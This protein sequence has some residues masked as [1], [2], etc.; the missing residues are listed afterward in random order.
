MSGS[1]GCRADQCGS[2]A[3]KGPVT[4]MGDDDESLATLDSGGC[5][6]SV[7]LVLLDGERFAG[8]GRLINLE[9]CVLGDNTAIG[10]D[11]STL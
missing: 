7:A 3:N 6:D 11:D 1:A 4:G 5:V 10:R 9:I 8:K 2:T